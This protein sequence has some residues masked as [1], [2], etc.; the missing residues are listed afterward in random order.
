MKEQEAG[1][2]AST[3][4]QKVEYPGGCK[5]QLSFDGVA[6]QKILLVVLPPHPLAAIFWLF[7]KMYVFGGHFL[8]KNSQD[9]IMTL[10]SYDIGEG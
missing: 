5:S 8:F 9:I 1:R 2:P 4:G 7:A 3:A 6:A 10:S